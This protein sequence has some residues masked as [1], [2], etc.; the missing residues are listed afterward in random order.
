M[1][2]IIKTQGTY[3]MVQ[4]LFVAQN[5]AIVYKFHFRTWCH[6]FF[7]KY[8]KTIYLKHKYICIFK[9]KS[10]HLAWGNNYLGA[11]DTYKNNFGIKP[12]QE[13]K[14]PPSMPY[15]DGCLASILSWVRSS[16]NLTKIWKDWAMCTDLSGE[17]GSD[18][19]WKLLWNK[20]INVQLKNYACDKVN[21]HRKT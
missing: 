14:N 11:H 2:I 19:N 5:T 15:T 4:Y 1:Y 3:S 17:T 10:N 20:T 8:H 21:L 13:V 7:I 18:L 9:V 12:I 6:V 16:I